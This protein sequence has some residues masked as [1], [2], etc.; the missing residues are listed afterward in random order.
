MVWLLI[1]SGSTLKSVVG[2][3]VPF[4]QLVGKQILRGGFLLK[5]N[6]CFCSGKNGSSLLTLSVCLVKLFPE[7]KKAS[8]TRLPSAKPGQ[9]TSQVTNVQK[10]GLKEE[11]TLPPP[12]AVFIWQKGLP[13]EVCLQEKPSPRG[14]SS[15]LQSHRT[16]K[17]DGLRDVTT[18][19][20]SARCSRFLSSLS[21]TASAWEVSAW[22]QRTREAVQGLLGGGL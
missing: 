17:S 22:K 1:T 20:R 5:K 15:C 21:G 9:V 13:A 14:F 10:Q 11:Q 3:R 7:G 19:R 8:A 12:G 6:N 18:L 4:C 16:G 2:F